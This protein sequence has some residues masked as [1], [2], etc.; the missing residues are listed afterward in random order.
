[1]ED[2]SFLYKNVNWHN[3]FHCR[4]LP[5]FLHLDMNICCLF[6][7]L[8]FPLVLFPSGLNFNVDIDGWFR[9]VRIFNV[10]INF[11]YFLQWFCRLEPYWHQQSSYLVTQYHYNISVCLLSFFCFVCIEQNFSGCFGKLLS[12]FSQTNLWESPTI[13]VQ[14]IPNSGV[15]WWGNPTWFSM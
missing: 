9:E 11:Y 8:D 12:Q 3:L 6:N 2:H 13:A 1:M 14:L 7:A 5:G 10:N 4:L 15:H